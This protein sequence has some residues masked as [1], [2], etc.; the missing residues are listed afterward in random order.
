[1]T[2]APELIARTA[3]LFQY[4][5]NTGINPIMWKIAQYM[6]CSSSRRQ[7]TTTVSKA[8]DIVPALDA[9]LTRFQKASNVPVD[10]TFLFMDIRYGHN[11]EKRI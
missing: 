9:H 2:C 10:I 5:Y 7:L 8:T 1:M 6:D 4:C 3:K 11:H